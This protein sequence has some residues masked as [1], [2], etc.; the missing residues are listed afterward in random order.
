[1]KRREILKYTALATGAAVSA[2]LASVILSGCQSE[3]VVDS[4]QAGTGLFTESEFSLLQQLVDVILPK[5]DSPS[6]SEVGVHTMIDHMVGKVY[7]AEDRS[8]FKKGFLV[9]SELL[10][11]SEFMGMDATGQLNFL[12]ELQSSTEEGRKI[13]QKAFLDLKQQT[14]AYYLNT[15]EIGKN[16]LNYLPVPGAY[17]ACITLEEVDGKAWA[18]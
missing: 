15:E 12:K 9:L 10:Q 16:Y 11:Q 5:T 3:A 7:S 18:L 14:I 2:P 8:V 4:D 13:G 6:A 1:M 17:D